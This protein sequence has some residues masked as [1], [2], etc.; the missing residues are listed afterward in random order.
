VLNCVCLCRGF[1]N[2]NDG[3]KAQLAK[4]E[5]AELGYSSVISKTAGSDWDCYAINSIKA[6]LT[7]KS[8]AAAPKR[9]PTRSERFRRVL[10]QN[11]SNNNSS[12]SGGRG[13]GMGGGGADCCV[14][15]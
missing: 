13:G 5:V 9:V 4:F 15:S 10:P 3:F 1:I 7:L 8:T 11:A 6:A 12:N 2:P 14:V